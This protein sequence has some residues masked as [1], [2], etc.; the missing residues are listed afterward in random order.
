MS[1]LVIYENSYVK[2]IIHFYCLIIN[3]NELTVENRTFACISGNRFKSIPSHC[4]PRGFSVPKCFAYYVHTYSHLIMQ[5][6]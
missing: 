4:I 3:S 2:E 5:H 1:M 6:A